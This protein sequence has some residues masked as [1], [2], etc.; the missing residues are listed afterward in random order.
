MK[1]T[2][3]TNFKVNHFIR[4]L[5][6]LSMK[7]NAFQKTAI[8]TVF[9]T[10][11]LI[12]IGGLVRA[13][14][15]G[16]GCPDWPRCFGTW[17]PP[18]NLS[19][20]PPQ[21]DPNQFNVVKTWTEYINRLVGVTIG[22]F[23]IATFIRSFSYRKT[24]PSVFYSSGLALALVLF[25]GWLGG[26]VVKT[27]LSEFMITLHMILALILVLTLLYATF[28]AS[29]HHLSLQI[30][31]AQ[32]KKLMSV[33]IVILTL[34]VVQIFLGTQVREGIDVIKNAENVIPR[35]E[36]VTQTGDIFSIHRTFSWLFVFATIYLFVVIRRE[37]IEGQLKRVGNYII[38][39]IVLQLVI[40]IGL[41]YLDMPRILQIAHLV[42]FSVL[43]CFEFL[44]L[45]MLG[46]KSS[47]STSALSS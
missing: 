37:K 9:A 15:A 40:G 25:Q 47:Q 28:K 43:M 11:F 17:V 18:T 23:I 22:L 5:L 13:S 27:G 21:F 33:L 42:S 35:S 26:Q 45:L 6:P 34:S 44:M 12:F 3:K 2:L 38:G 16:L 46:L 14:G 8:G 20:L 41:N 1:F 29:E 24:T 10:I 31:V 30:T 7:L 36:W 4:V 32:R 19:D 39:L